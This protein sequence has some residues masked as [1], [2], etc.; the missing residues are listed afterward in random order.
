MVPRVLIVDDAA[1]MR[2]MIRKILGELGWEIAGEAAD[3]E[4]ACQMFDQLHPDLM[5]LD[6]IMPK[7]TGLEALRDIRGKHP[8]AR[9]VVMTAVDQKQPVM[10]ALKLGAVDYV[11]KPFDSEQVKQTLGRLFAA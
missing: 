7:K 1:F 2:H 10:D 11:V 4:Q 5:T 6:L 9:V 8:Q 3:G